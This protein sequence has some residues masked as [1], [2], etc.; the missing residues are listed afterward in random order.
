MVPVSL[1][2][3]AVL[4]FPSGS[5]LG[6]RW[7]WVERGLWIAVA[8]MA[9]TSTFGPAA[10]E[11]PFD[12]PLEIA[13]WSNGLAIASNVAYVLWQLT[14]IPSIASVI[15]RL[16]RSRGIERQQVKWVAFAGGYLAFL[17][18]L[19]E[20]TFRL[21]FE[22]LYE[23]ASVLVAASV[24][25]IPISMALAMLRYRLYDIDRLVS[26]SVAYSLVAAAL[27]LVYAGGVVLLQ[28]ALPTSGNLAI[29]ASTLAAAA[30][31]NPLRVRVQRW[32]D[33]RFNRAVFD[34][35]REVD[36]FAHRL[37]TALDPA[38]ITRDLNVVLQTT[39]QPASTFVW[40]RNKEAG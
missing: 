27:F 34:A 13:R 19:V 37:R 25:F 39:V 9:L 11:F 33:R 4:R 28:S 24:L 16:R 26:R 15:V 18:F 10:D 29:A 32:V 31:F 38:T 1:L 7:R 14:S 30:L 20:V 6:P 40:I 3:T 2:I 8:L 35:E 17:V 23:S 21:F 5:L 22:P 12:N 36:D